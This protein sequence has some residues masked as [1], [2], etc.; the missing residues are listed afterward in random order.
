[1]ETRAAVL[2]CSR[3]L[4]KADQILQFAQKQSIEAS[5][6]LLYHLRCLPVFVCD[7]RT[8]PIAGCSWP[9]HRLSVVQNRMMARCQVQDHRWQTFG[10]M[11]LVVSEASSLVPCEGSLQ[12]PDEGKS[13]QRAEVAGCKTIHT[14]RETKLPRSRH[15][16][17]IPRVWLQD[18]EPLTSD[19]VGRLGP[20][21]SCWA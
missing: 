11:S 13:R 5:S 7:Q 12:K 4:Q 20:V 6:N 19:S 14:W 1:M 8:L 9:R 16:L 2:I 10:E 21:S 15:C 18:C 3:N 17:S